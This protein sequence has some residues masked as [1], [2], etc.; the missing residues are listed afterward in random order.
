MRAAEAAL[1]QVLMP[2]W[3][4]V[5]TPMATA[6]AH[7]AVPERADRRVVR[8]M[9]GIHDGAVVAVES[10]RSRRAAG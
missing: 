4:H 1:P 3:P 7:H 8:Q 5:S 9:I 2:I 10:R 6:G